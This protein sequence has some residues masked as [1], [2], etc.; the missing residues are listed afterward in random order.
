MEKED[1][2][3]TLT[4]PEIDEQHLKSAFEKMDF[5]AIKAVFAVGSSIEVRPYDII[6]FLEAAFYQFQ[7]V[8]KED[9]QQREYIHKV[10]EI[11]K[12]LAGDRNNTTGVAVVAPQI[13]AG[14]YAF[15]PRVH[16]WEMVCQIDDNGELIEAML[17]YKYKYD[18]IPLFDPLV[19]YLRKMDARLP[20]FEAKLNAVVDIFAKYHYDFNRIFSTHAYQ[21]A[22]ILGGAIYFGHKSDP[23]FVKALLRVGA[24]HVFYEN[25]HHGIGTKDLLLDLKAVTDEI[26]SAKED[27]SVISMFDKAISEITCGSKRIPFAIVVNM[28]NELKVN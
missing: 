10:T 24:R 22:T 25:V 20:T 5:D 4:A 28:I 6:N 1:K 14:F 16:P 18:W 12:W 15:Y 13:P 26:S 17:Q 2:E 7:N 8:L 23:R 19:F 3:Y 11:F 21:K 9:G 27:Q